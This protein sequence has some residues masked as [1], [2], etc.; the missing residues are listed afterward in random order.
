VFSVAVEPAGSPILS[1]TRAGLPL[2]AGVHGIQGIGAGFVPQ[3]LDLSL[4]DLIEAV[5]DDEAIAYTRRLA[6]EE[7]VMAGISSGAALAVA[8]RLA[9]RPEHGGKIIVAV[10][11]DSGERYLSS[12]LFGE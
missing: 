8:V 4:I 7:G 12:S 2:Q 6:K 10:L 11:P 3:N 9:K 5:D 1:Q